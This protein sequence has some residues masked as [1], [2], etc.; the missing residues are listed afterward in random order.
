MADPI[1]GTAKHAPELHEPIRQ[2][3]GSHDGIL[4]GLQDLAEL[5]E[6]ASAME[7]AR[8]K[9]ASVL[10]LFDKVVLVHHA[11]EEQELFVSVQR[12]C[13]DAREA[14]QVQT[15]VDK[16]KGE[17]RRIETLWKNIRPALVHTAAGKP[18][19]EPFAQEVA[20]LVR[21]YGQHAR[22]EEDVFLPLADQILARNQNHMAALDV[23]L[24]L[25]HA[26]PPRTSYI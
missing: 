10:H 8:S 15:L 20:T 16:L 17:H 22:F 1:Q 2:F 24:H 14:A 3:S 18:H 21:L 23:A 13:R 26:P 9:A 25:R 4:H 19:G 7:R 6:L 11:D 5:P 12:S